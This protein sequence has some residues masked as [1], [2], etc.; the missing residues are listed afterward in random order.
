[1]QTDDLATT[2]REEGKVNSL[3]IVK[4]KNK[5]RMVQY[6]LSLCFLETM[7]ENLPPLRKAGAL[8]QVLC[9]NMEVE[10][11]ERSSKSQIKHL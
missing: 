9:Q 11:S 7:E 3:R 5:I 6:F 8:S 1:M 4:P 10:L 2:A